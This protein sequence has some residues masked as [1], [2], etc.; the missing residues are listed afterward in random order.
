MLDGAHDTVTLTRAEYDA[1]RQK[2]D[3]MS[4]ALR[5]FGNDDNWH[6]PEF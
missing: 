4:R 3:D 6:Q 1:M 2:I 5:R